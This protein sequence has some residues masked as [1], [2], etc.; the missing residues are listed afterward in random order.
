M[1]RKEISRSYR[2]I[3]ILT[4]FFASMFTVLFYQWKEKSGFM[5]LLNGNE[6][7]ALC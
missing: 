6:F 1:W 3:T 4:V 2:V 5:D 7:G